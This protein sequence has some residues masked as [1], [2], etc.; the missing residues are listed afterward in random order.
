ML[1]F[2]IL[3]VGDKVTLHFDSSIHCFDID[4][5]DGDGS[6]RAR[7][8]VARRNQFSGDVREWEDNPNHMR[9]NG[10]CEGMKVEQGVVTVVGPILGSFIVGKNAWLSFVAEAG[11]KNM[12]TNKVISIERTPKST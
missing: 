12:I 2:S 4:E 1:D 9:L 8:K 11:E 3:T 5:T 6:L 10:S 7:L